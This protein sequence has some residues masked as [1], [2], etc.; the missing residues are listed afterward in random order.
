MIRFE[1]AVEADAA[2]LA[3]IQM[4]AFHSQN[5]PHIPK[6]SGP[7]GYDSAVWQIEMMT[8]VPYTKIIEGDAIVGGLI[9]IP[10]TLEHCHLERIYLDP[11]HHGRGI[12][13]ETMKWMERTWREYRR[14]T[15]RTPA[16]HVRNRKFYEGLGYVKVGEREVLPGFLMVEYEK[17]L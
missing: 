5:P 13:T 3:Q 15:L 12:G 9:L 6:L 11:L 10:K 16:F 7:P 17:R 14:W 2:E 8:Q 1:R 4:R